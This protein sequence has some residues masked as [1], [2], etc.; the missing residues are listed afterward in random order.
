LR[1]LLAKS[2]SVVADAFLDVSDFV[3]ADFLNFKA[4]VV[5]VDGVAWADELKFGYTEEPLNSLLLV[6]V[7]NGQK[8]FHRRDKWGQLISVDLVEAHQD[9]LSQAARHLFILPTQMTD[10]LRQFIV[11]AV[12]AKDNFVECLQALAVHE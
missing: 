10:Q 9:D 2:C 8:D 7:F 11:L 3:A 4:V 5:A 6:L 1:G 12:I